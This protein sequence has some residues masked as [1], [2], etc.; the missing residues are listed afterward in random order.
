MIVGR[1]LEVVVSVFGVLT[2]ATLSRLLPAV[3]LL[4]AGFVVGVLALVIGVSLGVDRAPTQV[5]V[6]PAAP[7]LPVPQRELRVIPEGPADCGTGC[8]LT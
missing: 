8:H 5:I 1:V 7:H 6:V 4:L 3:V 2:G